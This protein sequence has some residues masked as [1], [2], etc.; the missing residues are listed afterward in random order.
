MKAESLDVDQKEKMKNER[1]SLH[2]KE[3]AEKSEEKCR[4]NNIQREPLQ[5]NKHVIIRM[6]EIYY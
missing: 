5:L 2:Y 4:L 6:G 1:D 3:L